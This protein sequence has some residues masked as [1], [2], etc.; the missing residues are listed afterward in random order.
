[1][2]TS[3]LIRRNLGEKK[4]N[5]NP[6]HLYVFGV[7][8][9]T[10]VKT[11]LFENALPSGWIWKRWTLSCIVEWEIK[12]TNKQTTNELFLVVW[13]SHV[14]HST[15]K[16]ETTPNTRWWMTLYCGLIA[17]LKINVTAYNLWVAFLNK[18][19][20]TNKRRPDVVMRSEFKKI[21]K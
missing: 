16:K 17:L 6:P 3:M 7:R 14:T 8:I 10:A 20:T 4:K 9:E 13:H 2:C 19:P 18:R 21:N 12:K 11:E 5:Q 1:M 15:K